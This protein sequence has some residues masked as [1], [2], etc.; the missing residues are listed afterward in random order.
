M[1]ARIGPG[2][3]SLYESPRPS[4]LR[5]ITGREPE[6]K[7]THVLLEPFG[8]RST[9][10]LL[11]SDAGG[12]IV[13]AFWP[14]ELRPQAEYLY[15]DGRGEAM[16]SAALERGW[17]VWAAPHLAFF[18]A[19]AARRLYMEPEIDPREYAR[20]WEGPDARWIGQ[21]EPEE[22]RSSLWPWLKQRGYVSDHEDRVLKEW[23][24]LLGRRPAH[25][26]PALRLHRR[27]HAAEVRE[28]PEREL[29]ARIRGDVNAVLAAAKDATLTTS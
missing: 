3:V 12:S 10:R 5:L 1:T 21:H 9:Q 24:P 29:A 19:P 16:V 25:L 23:I 17:Q 26:R 28:L 8:I 14:A 18:T 11:V 15:R 2:D 7:G 4:L 27:W 22:L 20:R 6:P 13:V